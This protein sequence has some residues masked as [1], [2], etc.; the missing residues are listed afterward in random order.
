V[1]TVWSG[2]FFF[3]VCR[4]AKCNLLEDIHLSDAVSEGNV[5]LFLVILFL[6]AE[7]N[8]ISSKE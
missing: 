6:T 7:E 4:G 3:F 8:W 5:P 1:L 2:A